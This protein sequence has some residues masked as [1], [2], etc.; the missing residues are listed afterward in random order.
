MNAALVGA[1]CLMSA[2]AFAWEFTPGIPCLL[3]H[4]TPDVSVELTYDPTGPVYSISLTQAVPFAPSPVFSMQFTG[5]QSLSISTGQHRLSNG[6][7][8]VT[9]VDSGF[10]NVLNGLQFNQTATAILGPQ[11][12]VV[13]LTDAA[14]AVAA[15]RDCDTL[16]TA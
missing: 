16:P 1:L 5:P 8:T 7:R 11:Q 13:P 15:F 2:P 9:V 12:I 10:G 6:G 4:E 3:T 14:D